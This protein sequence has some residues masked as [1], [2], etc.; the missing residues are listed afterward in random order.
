[1]LYC[2]TTGLVTGL[3]VQKV[4]SSTILL[5]G[6]LVGWLFVCLIGWLG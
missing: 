1:M 2:Q 5:V 6:W 3:A 4:T